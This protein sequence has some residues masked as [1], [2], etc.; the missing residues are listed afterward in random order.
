MHVLVESRS[1]FYVG[2]E[3]PRGVEML[4]P[5]LCLSNMPEYHKKR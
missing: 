3:F 2:L 1:L 4:S 5:C